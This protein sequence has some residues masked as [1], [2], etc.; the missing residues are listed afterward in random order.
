[1]GGWCT[2]NLPV[3]MPNNDYLSW[4][5]GEGQEE[6]VVSMNYSFSPAGDFVSTNHNQMLSAE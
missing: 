3:I 2:D 4:H 1:M 6:M 5:H